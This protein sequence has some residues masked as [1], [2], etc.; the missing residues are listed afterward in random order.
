M[1]G[2]SGIS[3]EVERVI[4]EKL[5]AFNAGKTSDKGRYYIL[6]P[7]QRTLYYTLW[8]YNPAATYHHYIFL[9]TL[10]LNIISSLN[11]AMR[12][13]ANSYMSLHITNHTD[14][15]FGSSGN[16]G[17]DI[18]TFGK[19]RGHKLQEIYTI[20]PRYIA[21]LADKYEP[22]VRNE[23]RF[24]ELAVTYNRIYFDLHTPRKYKIQ[25][26]QYVGSVGEKLTDLTL[27]VYRVR[28]EDDPYKTSIVRGT[29]YFY[30]DQIVTAIDKAGNLYT[31]TVKA[32]GS[33]LQSRT[34]NSYAHPYK[35][36]EKLFIA[37]AKVMKHFES[38]NIKYTRLGYIKYRKNDSKEQ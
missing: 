8:F 34:L 17:D 28:I 19:Y 36:G 15:L 22:R 26:S 11:K 25:T 1:D 20:D 10:E 2:I 6:M 4:R 30:V 7:N 24:K 18:I 9:D 35:P 33:S 3:S 38:R 13:V 29:P 27:T 14:Q 37:S 23:F 31:F 21:W 16:N 5:E 12:L 32:S